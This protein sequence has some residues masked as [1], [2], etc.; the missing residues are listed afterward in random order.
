MA[1]GTKADLARARTMEATSEVCIVL[2]TRKSAVTR[3]W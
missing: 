3:M 1:S 2:L